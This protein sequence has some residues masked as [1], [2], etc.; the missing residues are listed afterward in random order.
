MGLSKKKVKVLNN[1]P[2]TSS[3]CRQENCFYKS[4]LDAKY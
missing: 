2:L 4:S 1:V 3:P